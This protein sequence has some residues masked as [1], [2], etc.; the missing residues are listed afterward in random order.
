MI[1]VKICGL[2]TPETVDAAVDAGADYIGFNFFPPSPRFLTPALAAPL[3]ARAGAVRRVGLFVNP[4]WDDIAAVLAAVPLEILQI[5]GPAETVTAIRARTALPIWQSIG[6][7]STADLPG[8]DNPADGYVL[9]AK[10]PPGATRPGGNAVLADW[11]LF[12]NFRPAGGKPWLLAG[13][14]TP[15]N[16]G[17]AIREAGAPGVDV[18]SGVETAPGMKS[19]DLIRVFIAAARATVFDDFLK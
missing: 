6:L 10:P 11:S 1:A 12:E 17:A 14:L 18:A 8:P 3:A 19:A 2:T 16:V 7:A 4:V 15:A 13:G 5:Y 9:E